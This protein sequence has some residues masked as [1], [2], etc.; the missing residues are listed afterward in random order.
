MDLLII[1]TGEAYLKTSTDKFEAV[2]LDKASVFP[3]AQL[4]RVRELVSRAEARGFAD[5]CIKK[6]VLREEDL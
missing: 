3:M 6:L 1:K 5:L 4:D 2:K